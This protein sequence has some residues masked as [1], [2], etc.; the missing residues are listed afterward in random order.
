MSP[1]FIFDWKHYIDYAEE[2]FNDGDFSQEN[3]Y[4]IRT[5]ISGAYYGL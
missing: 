3:E 1:D 5:G 2:I 4:L